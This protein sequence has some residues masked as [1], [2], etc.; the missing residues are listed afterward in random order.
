MDP[1]ISG[2]WLSS[3]LG[4]GNNPVGPTSIGGQPLGPD[5]GASGNAIPG[6]DG[7]TSIGGA[8]LGPNPNGLTLQKGLT[9][10]GSAAPAIQRAMAQRTAQQP[11]PP[12]LQIPQAHGGQYAQALAQIMA[13]LKQQNQIGP[14]GVGGM[15]NSMNPMGTQ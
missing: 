4:G 1:D 8:P 9:A 3:I 10:V 13:K 15:Q 2:G 12:Q 11:A 7:P 5:P 6:A 14:G